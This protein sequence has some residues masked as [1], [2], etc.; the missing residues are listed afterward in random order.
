VTIR[1]SLAN[2][3]RRVAHGLSP[4]P[5]RRSSTGVWQGASYDRLYQDWD[6]WT[7]SPEFETRYGFRTMRARAR[8]FARNN[9]WIVG[10]LDELANNV[11]GANGIRLHAQIKNALGQPAKTTN[12]AIEEAWD[13]WGVP[14]YASADGQDSWIELQRQKIITIAVDGEV[15]VRRLRGVDNPYG[16]AQQILDADLVDETYNVPSLP[17]GNRIV[18]GLEKDRRNRTVAVH[19]WNRYAEDM[20]STVE[21]TRERIAAED[22]QHLFVR[23][24]RA[25][26]PRGVTW[27]APVLASL[28]HEQEYELSHLVAARAG[29][30]KMAVILNKNPNAIEAWEP[31]KKGEQP[32]TFAM[33]P[34]IMPELLPGQEIE[35]IDPT[36]PSVGYEQFVMAVHRATARGLRT[37]Y[38]T[39]TGD[40]RQANYASQRAGTIPERDRWRGL[41]GWLAM[42]DNRVTYRDWVDQA[43]LRGAIG[44][45]G[46]LGA[47]FYAVTWHGR[48]WKW[49]EPY[50]DLRAAKMEIDLGLNSR[51][52]LAGE[53]GY[54]YE[55]I[56]DELAL[57]QQYAEA[58]DVDT[59]GNQMSGTTPT[60]V[61]PEGETDETNQ[62]D[63]DGT[64]KS[65]GSGARHLAAL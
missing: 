63:G 62:G 37:S 55:D 53:R 6:T 45:D 41:Q 13:A 5:A 43:T 20:N 39:L 7:V 61:S 46:R 15:F 1:G 18:M 50:N 58:N 56:V 30:S 4:A 19:A 59:S 65:S 25:N 49:T 16:Y 3:L 36:F 29:A 33:E 47:D 51:T 24:H 31:P 22:I 27:L 2:A 57:E 12:A 28:R 42:H 8:Y 54:D 40:L 64:G 48:G 44:V 34:G 38:M 60:T 35:S 21:R 26:I 23:W 11:V 17:N 10:F 9:P 14:E 52:R 32:K